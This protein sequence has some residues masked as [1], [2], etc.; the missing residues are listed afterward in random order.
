[1]QQQQQRAAIT[2][3]VDISCDVI[4]EMQLALH[5][6]SATAAPR[7]L[8][9]LLLLL[10]LLLLHSVLD[11]SAS[12]RAEARLLR[13]QSS[14]A[15]TF[16]E[17]DS[18]N[19]LFVYRSTAFSC[20]SDCPSRLRSQQ[21]RPAA[22]A[23]NATA[24]AAAV[25]GSYPYSGSS[26]ICLAA[27]H[28]GVLSAVLGGSVFVSRFHRADWSNSSSQ[29]VFP[30]GAER[31]SLSNG[32]NSSDVEQGWLTLPANGSVWSYTVRGR[33]EPVSQRRQAPFSPRSRHTHAAWPLYF[34]PL[35]SSLPFQYRSFHMVLGRLRR[36]ALPQRR[37]GGR[38]QRRQRHGRPAVEAA[39]R[40]A[41]LAASG[42]GPAS[43]WT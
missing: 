11:T 28:S 5:R 7:W 14:C 16:T 35:A 23:P 30:H 27:I 8:P 12:C 39:A 9:C 33:G 3:T 22:A 42:H 10:L 19:P 6:H 32:V 34:A 24:S 13:L 25:F 18:A 37:L 31:G 21:Q 17:L 43:S 29:T 26:S 20:P 41:L 38:A 2:L 40:R 4:D 1:M 15:T 36:A